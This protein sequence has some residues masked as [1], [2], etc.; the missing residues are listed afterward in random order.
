MNAF[1]LGY[2]H[3]KCDR[4]QN[5]SNWKTLN[6]MPDALRLNLQNKMQHIKDEECR[7]TNMGFFVQMKEADG[8]ARNY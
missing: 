4:C 6:Q 1:C 5:Q 7:L 2:M 3:E 8:S